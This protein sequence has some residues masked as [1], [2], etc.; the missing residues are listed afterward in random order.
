MPDKYRCKYEYSGTPRT[1]EHTWSILGAD[2]GMHLWIRGYGGKDD[3]L[4]WSGGLEIHYRYP[5]EHMQN[6]PPSSDTC[7]LLKCPCWHDGS[8]LVASEIWIPRWHRNPHDHDGMFRALCR[9][10]D[11]REVPTALEALAR[12]AARNS[13]DPVLA[14]FEQSV[15]DGLAAAVTQ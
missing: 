14:N 6:Q 3:D 8:S 12:I 5:P 13:T 11:A 2:A 15:R 7:W 1:P 10:L 9:D 4:R